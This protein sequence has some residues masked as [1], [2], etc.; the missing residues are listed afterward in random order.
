[1]LLKEIRESWGMFIKPQRKLLIN[2]VNKAIILDRKG[3]ILDANTNLFSPI[4]EESLLGY[5][6]I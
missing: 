4:F 3:Y 5:L 6:N 2:S 1:M